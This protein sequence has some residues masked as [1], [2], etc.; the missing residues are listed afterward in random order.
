[1]KKTLML[2]AAMIALA[3]CNNSKVA[4]DTDSTFDTA[5]PVANVP[6]EEAIK[7][8]VD[9]MGNDSI[10]GEL[11][12]SFDFISR[13]EWIEWVKSSVRYDRDHD[14]I[15]FDSAIKLYSSYEWITRD[16]IEKWWRQ[17]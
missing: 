17:R 3:A 8:S 1:M 6:T 5:T 9:K 10:Y 4:N 12:L 16:S 2:C 14:S 11:P 15:T 7:D 13:E